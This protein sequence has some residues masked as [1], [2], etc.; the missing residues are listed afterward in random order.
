M[1]LIERLEWGP[2]IGTIKGATRGGEP[3]GD[4]RPD[5]AALASAHKAARARW[6]EIRKIERGDIGAVN[7]NLEAE[8]L[9]LRRVI[10]SDPTP[11]ERASAEARF[12]ETGRRLTAQY[13][14]LS[15]R[16]QQL[17]AENEKDRLVLEEIGGR[18]V[19]L[20]LSA[21]VRLIAPNELSW[22]GSLGVYLSRWA[23]F[24]LDEPRE[25]NTEGG[26]MP[27]IFGTFAMTVLLVIAVAPFGVITALYLREYASQG[28][29]IA[30]V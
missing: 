5:S 8:R 13:E 12:A 25:A 7:H 3:I 15:V 24:L 29:I 6:A 30:F 19:A 17:R 21:V 20:P 10:I 28:R 11:A 27:A 14:T 22:L 2:F 9:R 1:I 18:E 26:I 23:E 4:L 16:A